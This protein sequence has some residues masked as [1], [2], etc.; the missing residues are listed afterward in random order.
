MKSF[1]QSLSTR[2]EF[3]LVIGFAFG[4]SCL[5]SID[6]V[7]RG[8]PQQAT[9]FT[10]QALYATLI[11]EILILLLLGLL[12]H[13]RGW[14]LSDFHLKPSW[15]GTIQG[16]GLALIIYLI[17]ILLSNIV[18]S[19][20]PEAFS[21]TNKAVSVSPTMSMTPIILVSIINPVFEEVF[22][23]AYVIN[24]LQKQR[25]VWFAVNTSVAIRLLY[26]SYQG[27]PGLL[28]IIPMG[29]LFALFYVRKQTLWPLLIAHA[30]W[31]MLP[32]YFYR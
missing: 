5:A 26:H 6:I 29:L 12:L 7:L 13:Y 27:I 22:V 28:L 1:L 4:L 21:E 2:A 15:I 3:V 8:F 30:F 25:G 19:I 18:S 17:V 14:K 11:Y 23:C 24:V 20:I 16:P 32:L 9:S 10:D 31:D